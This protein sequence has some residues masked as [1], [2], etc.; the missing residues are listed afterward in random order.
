MALARGYTHTLS[1]VRT[2]V[3]E[4][5]VDT[6]WSAQAHDD[7]L[8]NGAIARALSFLHLKRFGS[9]LGSSAIAD[10]TVSYGASQPS[11]A[12]PTNAQHQ[13]I[14]AVQDISDSGTPRDIPSVPISELEKRRSDAYGNRVSVYTILAGKAPSTIAT[15]AW[16]TNAGY[17]S[18]TVSAGHSVKVGDQVTFDTVTSGGDEATPVTVTHVFSTSIVWLSSNTSSATEAGILTALTR[19]GVTQQIAVRSTPETAVPLRFITHRRPSRWAT[20]VMSFRG[21]RIRWSLW[22]P[23]PLAV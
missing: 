12:L 16:A 22:P 4:I 13:P 9:S 10:E 19:P 7:A 1:S 21:P 5:M 6:D 20:M 2:L 11:V 23:A 14:I 8:V 3:R 17:Q 15:S 18:V